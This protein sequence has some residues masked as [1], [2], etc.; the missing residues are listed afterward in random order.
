MNY[1]IKKKIKQKKLKERNKFNYEIR[2][3]VKDLFD[4]LATCNDIDEIESFN[5]FKIKSNISIENIINNLNEIQKIFFN[6]RY[7][8]C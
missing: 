4:K 2:K 1:Y 3:D 6:K 7:K 5:D 8:Y